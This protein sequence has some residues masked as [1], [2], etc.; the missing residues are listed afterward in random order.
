M[1]FGLAQDDVEQVIDVTRGRAPGVT[2][3]PRFTELQRKQ[4]DDFL[5]WGFIDMGA[6]WEA[7]DAFM[8]ES[9]DDEDM[10]GEAFDLD[11]YIAE[12]RQ[13]MDRITFTVSAHHD[14]FIIDIAALR[15]PGAPAGA[16]Y[17]WSQ[18][19]VSHWAD[20]VPED[21]L[22]F[23][24]GYDFYGQVYRP[25]YDALH[26]L[27]L[28]FTDPYCS[29]APLALPGV[30]AG[31]EYSETDDPIY[32]Q[33]YDENGEFDFEAFDAWNTEIDARFTLPDGSYDY[34]GYSEYIDSL[35]QE[36]CAD[37]RKTI[38]DVI[39]EWEQE[40]GFDLEDDLLA[41]LTGEFAFALGARNLEAAEPEIEGAAMADVTDPVR[42]DTS[43]QA[44]ARWLSAEEDVAI[45]LVA[46]PRLVELDDDGEYTAAWTTRP[47]GGAGQPGH[48]VLGYPAEY[49][50]SVS[51]GAS[52][53]S[54]S[55]SGDW[56]RTMSLLPPEPTSIV[57]V[58]MAQLLDEIAGMEDA[59][60]EFE[61]ATDGRMQLEDLERIRSV[62][63]ATSNIEDGQAM[64]VLVLIDN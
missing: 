60:E 18:P 62:A 25:A 21:T 11:G 47:P 30:P 26:T 7:I 41:L 49:V 20:A 53:S 40:V 22:L 12:A 56:Q 58:N 6:A 5:I 61:D 4:V 51:E 44:I 59:A 33:F 55:A 37:K 57:Y 52:D 16:G 2:N 46:D 54:L 17:A 35:Y 36:A 48:L 1:I 63:L 34:A 43:L 19:F 28:S 15:A 38:D 64:R 27:D 45:D 3:D 31:G 50:S 39:S 8:A 42:A 32:G 29:S 23:A 13:S 14:G 24:A 10:F 9:E